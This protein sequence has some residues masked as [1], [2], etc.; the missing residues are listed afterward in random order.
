M[1][2]RNGALSQISANGGRQVLILPSNVEIVGFILFLFRRSVAT[3]GALHGGP[4]TRCDTWKANL[5]LA[6]LDSSAVCR[7]GDSGRHQPKEPRGKYGGYGARTVRVLPTEHARYQPSSEHGV[8]DATYSAVPNTQRMLVRE[9][10]ATILVHRSRLHVRISASALRLRQI[11][12]WPLVRLPPHGVVRRRV[13][14]LLLMGSR[15]PTGHCRQ[16]NHCSG[17][18]KEKEGQEEKLPQKVGR[19]ANPPLLVRCG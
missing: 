4:L 9:C 1:R 3:A 14:I 19:A 13:A 8:P 6:A 10:F 11:C 2:N 15:A 5:V 16:T 12:R 17:A 18:D 7:L